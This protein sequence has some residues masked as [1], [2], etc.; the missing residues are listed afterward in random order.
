MST[1]T[2]LSASLLSN[3]PNFF[4]C[5]NPSS[6][7]TAAR[8]AISASSKPLCRNPPRNFNSSYPSKSLRVP[9][10]EAKTLLKSSSSSSNNNNSDSQSPSSKV[11][12]LSETLSSSNGFVKMPAAPWMKG[13]LLLPP[14]E[15]LDFSKSKKKS[16]SKG[17]DDENY[18]SWLT[19]KV[20]GGRGR[21]AMRDIVRS[22]TKLKETRDSEVPHNLP[23]DG[24]FEFRVSLDKVGGD[25]NSKLGGKMPWA[26]GEKIVIPRPKKDKVVTAAQLTLPK[27]LLKRL[28]IEAARMKKWV[29]VKKAGVTQA[30]VDEIR[31]IWRNNELA[32][33][34]FDIPLC[35][36]M[37]RAREIVETKTRGLVVWC[38]K[39]TLVVY[40][41]CNHQSST[42]K[43]I[44]G[45]SKDQ[46]TTSQV[47]SV[48][49]ATIDNMAAKGRILDSLSSG[50]CVEENEAMQSVSGTLYEREADRLLDGLGP[51]FIDW[52]RPKPLPIDADLLPEVVTDFQPPFRLSPPNERPKLTDDE[53]TY[54]RKLA[55][56]LPTHFVLGR[57]K[58]IQGLAAAILKLWEKSLIVKI[59]VK[60]GVPNVNNE[61]MAS[62]LK[63]LTGGVLILRNKFFIILYRGKD[64]LPSRVANLISG[65]E[66]ELRRFHLQEED[67]RQKAFQSLYVTDDALTNGSTV[68]TFSEFQYIQT[69][70]VHLDS[71]NGDLEV[72]IEAEKEKL[73]KELR[74]QERRLY[75]LKSKIEISERHLAKLNSAWKPSEPVADRE[76]ITEEERQCFRKIGR[77]MNRFLVLGRRGVF[78]GV[79]GGL[80]QHWKHREIVKVVTLQRQ[81]FQVMDTA[82]LLE[83]E[84]DGILV[85]IEKLRKGH[86]IILYRG[87]NYRRQLKLE[88]EN[89]LTKRAALDRSLEM[90]R[91]GSLKFFAY[92]RQRTISD[93]KLKLV[94]T[95][96]YCKVREIDMGFVTRHPEDS[97]TF[98]KPG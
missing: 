94:H 62:E 85:S 88:P 27:V 16:S 44:H 92:Q 8:N 38:K 17:E 67:A 90:Q 4:N 11:L 36:N 55:R 1:A 86:A 33:L 87:K 96:P 28:R 74:K 46:M 82:R 79:I 78:D 19:E 93:L 5:S 56:P 80:H 3:T 34:K 14:S 98:I 10:C 69:K 25:G 97:P 35:R 68:G 91:I 41:G 61:E 64:F 49:F 18:D 26:R 30:V 89:L 48:G 23:E 24:E 31:F 40:R 37:D 12:F 53:L 72:K 54:L 6:S 73:K 59:A 21:Q 2:F 29:K 63:R 75:I 45:E 57:N 76:M 22:I 7:S 13:P 58:Y 39:D 43:I 42:L 65:R 71:G 81:F 51:R 60:W 66:A 32:M 52:W 47:K 95:F 50:F 15:V 20:K 70:C 84:S 77:K 83:I 9:P